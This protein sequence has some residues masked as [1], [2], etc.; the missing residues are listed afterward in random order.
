MRLFYV[1]SALLLTL[2][3]LL[4][5][6]PERR[7]AERRTANRRSALPQYSTAQLRQQEAIQQSVR[8]A[9]ETNYTKA[10]ERARAL[11]RPIRQVQPDGSVQQLWGL[12]ERG[13]LLYEQTYSNARA[14]N[15]TR[16]SDLYTGGR[17][18]LVLSGNSPNVRDR[19]GIWDSGR[20][21]SS[22][23]DFGG[24]VTQMDN[25]G[26]V[27]SHAT[28]VAGTMMAAGLNPLARGMA[29]GANLKA[30]DFGSG[31]T[32]MADAAG[33][34]LVSNHSYGFT[35]G[36]YFN[37]SRTTT[38]KWEWHGDTTISDREDYKFGFYDSRTRTWDRIAANAPY[39][40][41]VKSAGNDH[42]DN[43][44]GAGQPYYLAT[45]NV[46]STRTRNDQNGYDQISTNGTAKNIMTVA[47]VSNIS[48]G[49]NAPSDVQIASFSSWGPTDD[50][51]IKPDIAAVGVSLLS[52][53][54]RNDSSYAVLSGTSMSSPNVTGSLLLLQELYSQRNNG[55]FMRASTLKG[56]AIHTANEAGTSPGPDYRFGWGLLNT[57]RAAEVLLNTNA[58][59]LLNERT[60]EQGQTYSIPVVASGRGPLVVTICWHDPE[61]VATNITAAN[62]NNRTPKLV[63]DLDLRVST[64]TAESG[65]QTS[66]PWVLNPDAPDQP[67]TTSDNIRDNVEQVLIPN[68]VP[69]RSYTITVTH[70][71]SLTNAKQDYVLLAS[72]VGGTA[73]C[74][75]GPV[76]SSGLRIDQVQ[77]GSLNQPGSGTCT[78]YTDFMQSPVSVQ[79]GQPVPLVITVGTCSTV[80]SISTT[81]SGNISISLVSAPGANAVV[82]AFA[83]WNANGSF[84]DPG[85][86]L[87]TSGVL[88]V[89][90]RFS[91][92]ITVP[93]NVP[94]NQ[95][96]RVRIVLAESTNP[97]LVPACGSYSTGETQEYLIRT[98]RSAND[99]GV[100]AIVTPDAS[101][102]T[103]SSSPAVTVRIRNFG[104]DTQ[105]NVVVAVT[106][107][108]P[109]TARVVNSEQTLAQLAN[110]RDG[111][112]RVPLPVGT[113]LVSGRTYRIVV[114]TRLPNDQNQTNDRL[115]D[116]RTIAA[117]PPAATNLSALVCGNDSSVALRN[118]GTGTAFWYDAMTG[119]NL[120][121]VGN[122]TSTRR[123][124]TAFYVGLN[125]LNTTIGPANKATFGGGTYAGNFGPSPLI[126]TRVPVLLESARLYIAS[127][128][129]LTF[130]IRRL[131]DVLVSSVSLNVTP[132]RNTSLTA[133]NASGQLVDDPNDPGI[134]YPLNLRIPS[135]GDYKITLDYE[136]GASI[137]R[138]NVGVTGFPY[139]IRTATGDPIVTMRGSLF[140]ATAT[141]VDTLTSAWYYLY[142]LRVRS[143]DCPA[144]QRTAV[145]TSATA[146]PT[147]T[148][149][150]DGSTTICRGAGVNLTASA[151][152][153]LSYQWLLNG[154][155]ISG[156]I[157]NTYRASSE[158]AYVVQISSN[159]APASSGAVQIVVREVQLPTLTVNGLSLQSNA[160]VSNQWLLN[161]VPI[162]GATGSLLVASQTGRYAVRGNVN[163]C[164]EAISAEVLITILATDDPTL[165]AIQAFPNPTTNR[166]RVR[167]SAQSRSKPPTLQLVT[168][169]GMVVQEGPM[170]R[171]IDFFV[172]D[173]DLRNQPPGTFFVVI[174]EDTGQKPGVIRIIK[175]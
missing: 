103:A 48:N 89:G 41:I 82:K 23:I 34:Y 174:Q 100:V 107:T 75:S 139:Q 122:Q 159:C 78:T 94:E 76:S 2:A 115:V 70:K 44:P 113:Q 29:F 163:G 26:A 39:Y 22:H 123:R 27:D 171:E 86:L 116:E 146:P 112:V 43:G 106:L 83:D 88:M 17:L 71:S 64:A 98:I 157:G 99:I 149:A 85:E 102:C 12:D 66:L 136:D 92:T 137:F 52:T 148:V 73:Y 162:A 118:N 114:S 141:R 21:L 56:L 68:A 63:N 7:T 105:R 145:A 143:L 10:V 147:L 168:T 60:L 96:V 35:A 169:T 166:I 80:N 173:L 19:L 135:A 101:Y 153:A 37:D 31:D 24:R 54:T 81:I 97:A 58:N 53:S 51:R 5:A 167:V 84:D 87:G 124:Q 25:P 90:E 61:S 150:A 77:L 65:R 140:N 42:G 120:L 4:V 28:H 1:L 46:I 6:Q 119:D 134:E 69:G 49:Y 110:F 33:T 158:G 47:A 165:T 111:L 36:W 152:T 121:A 129:T 91:G 130:S 172:A 18:G 30:Y 125:T 155:P 40:L 117:A 151:S 50:G 20:V 164:G 15:T 108:D 16:T 175:L 67:A 3:H 128:G 8:V 59:Y 55:Q 127:A 144:P 160:T 79:V 13:N 156:A 14:A 74:T 72:G 104:T 154:Q 45:R 131:D 11:G 109:T 132:S 57:G 32:E 133:V 38:T 161:G 126:S 142:N 62:L 95:L 93:A 170:H 138:S 9:E